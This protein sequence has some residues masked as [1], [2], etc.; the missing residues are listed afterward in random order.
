[1][2][3]EHE[4]L[5]MVD[6]WDALLVEEPLDLAERVEVMA[7]LMSETCQQTLDTLQD[8]HAGHERLAQFLGEVSE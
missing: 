1:M 7:L 8:I 5:A 2:S 4:A 3:G 6:K